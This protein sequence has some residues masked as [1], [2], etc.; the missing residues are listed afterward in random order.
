[1]LCGFTP[2][3]LPSVHVIYGLMRVV[4]KVRWKMNDQL[5]CDVLVV[6]A[7][8][9]GSAAAKYCAE[10]GLKTVLIEKK[11]LPRDKVCTG[12]IMGTWAFTLIQETF[13]EIPA[14][15]LASPAQLIG[16]QLHVSG[17]DVHTLKTHTLLTWR[18]D[19]DGWFV[20][21]A[22]DSGTIVKENARAVRIAPHGDRIR[23][24]I[25]HDGQPHTV[26]PRF[27]IGA[28]GATSIVRKA[29]VPDLKVPYS[30]PVRVWYQG[31][32]TL[33]KNYIHWFFPRRLPRPRFNINQKDGIILL[34]GAGVKELSEEI[35]K[36]LSPFG[37]D[38]N[39]KPFKKDGCT[40]AL[41][42]QPLIDGR[43]T[44]A[45]GNVLLV[46]D[47][48]GLILPITFEGIGTALKSGIAAASAIIE[49]MHGDE[50][51]APAYLSAIQ[52]I[53]DTIRHLY[54]DQFQLKRKMDPVTQHMAPDQIA[55]YLVAAYNETLIQQE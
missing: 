15:I 6:G 30:G 43:F 4:D 47:A 27:V 2:G 51:A 10:A 21:R 8:P 23:V 54:K 44:P 31:N 18:K 22:K 49:N 39:W 17:T 9:G 5:D 14:S 40:I 34:E 45:K 35:E 37:F 13:G 41:L 29:V 33:D 38:S 1:M 19:L 11:T 28:D 24:D 20:K 42:H 55:A 25:V 53:I 48:A 46:G 12:M 32:L 3:F 52:E 7:G 36:T 16:H 50:D 26:F